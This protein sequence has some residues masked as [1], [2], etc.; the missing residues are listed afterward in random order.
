MSRV[1]KRAQIAVVYFNNFSLLA[2]SDSVDLSG[3]L[4]ADEAILGSTPA[5]AG[6]SNS[7]SQEDQVDA[8]Q[9]SSPPPPPPK[10]KSGFRAA[11]GAVRE[12][13]R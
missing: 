2:R 3:E 10:K 1:K 4:Y 5:A 8:A 13:L 11:M 9:T 7:Q 12:L 6:G